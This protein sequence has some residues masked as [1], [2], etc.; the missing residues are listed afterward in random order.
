[1]EGGSALS[2][3]R[4]VGKLV[5]LQLLRGYKWGISPMFPPACRFVPSCSE[6]AME[7][8][9]RY[10]AVR[11]GLRAL[12]RVLRCHP[13]A[14]GGYDPVVKV[15]AGYE[16]A[17]TLP[18]GLKP[19]LIEGDSSQRLKRCA[20]QNL[21]QQNLG[22]QDLSYP[23]LSYPKLSHQNLIDPRSSSPKISCA[24]QNLNENFDGA[25]LTRGAM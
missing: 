18:Q 15:S 23:E 8:V 10:G 4:Q 5:V 25:A 1:V 14:A 24:T 17:T 22:H 7:A 11:G 3:M 12:M 13:F 16:G 6:Y 21:R 20:T 2:V 9:E 19:A